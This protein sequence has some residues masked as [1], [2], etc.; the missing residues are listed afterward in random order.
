[1]VFPM[2]TE[3]IQKKYLYNYII[4]SEYLIVDYIEFK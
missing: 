4:I 3:D 2:M 1:M